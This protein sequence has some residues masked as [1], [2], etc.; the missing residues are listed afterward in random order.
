MAILMPTI[1]SRLFSMHCTVCGTEQKASD[2]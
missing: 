1:V 2:W